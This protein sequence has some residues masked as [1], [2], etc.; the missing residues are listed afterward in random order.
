MSNLPDN[1]NNSASQNGHTE[2]GAGPVFILT[3]SRSGSTLLRFILDSHPDL[4]CPPETMIGST[5]ATMTRLWECLEHSGDAERSDATQPPDI[6]AEGLSMIRA[7]L[8]GAYGSYLKRRGKKRWCDKSLDTFQYAATIRKIYPEAKFVCLVRHCMDVVASGVKNCPWGVTRFGFD[9]FVAQY[10]G[11][12]VAAIGTYWLTC[13]R[14][15]VEF[16]DQNPDSC[17]MVRYEDLV[18]TPET[19]AADILRFIDASPSPGI[20]DACFSLP[21]EERGPGDEKIWFTNR[22]SADSMGQGI[23]VP[24][25]ALPPDT[26]VSINQI[27]TRLRYKAISDD[28][29]ASVGGF[30][31]RADA[32]VAPAAVASNNH[33]R[34]ELELIA[35][36]LHDRLAGASAISAEIVAQWPS[37]AGVTVRLVAESPGGDYAEVKWRFPSAN[38]GNGAAP[39]SDNTSSMPLMIASPATWTSFLEENANVIT[40]ITD[41]RLRCFNPNDSHRL[42]SDE[43]HAIGALL[44]LATVPVDHTPPRDVISAAIQPRGTQPRLPR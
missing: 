7:A 37:V 44:G 34:A 5:C 36:A 2:A 40:A 33:A 26:R 15:I 30:D 19:T 9:P 43:L 8:D 27:L 21:H 4:A 11:N 14:A 24:A 31:P 38:G 41:G 39:P 42:R 1:Q 10:P 29:K 35:R 16:H 28:W 18:T 23:S 6:S 17:I 25:G 20:A 22:V 13:T 12:N 3:A 32:S